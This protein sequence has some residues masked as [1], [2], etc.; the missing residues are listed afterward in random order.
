VRGDL[1]VVVGL[2]L[3]LAACERPSPALICH[4]A[5]CS[6]SVESSRDATL[7][8]LD[9]S[10]ALRDDGRPLFDGIEID[11]FW[12]GAAAGCRFAHD[13]DPAA[14]PASVAAGR[15]AEHLATSRDATW[16]GEPFHLFLDLK[17]H[18]G[19]SKRSRHSAAQ[20]AL[21]A[22]CA[23]DVVAV[24]RD[25]ARAG[26]HA[27]EVVF[28]SRSPELLAAVAAESRFAELSTGQVELRLGGDIGIPR[29]LSGETWPLSDF[30]TSLGLEVMAYSADFMTQGQYQAMRALDLE[31]AQW[32]NTTTIEALDG[33]ER[34]R[35]E[36]VLSSEV[37]LVRSWLR[38]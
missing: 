37:P 6:G 25:G 20:R 17:A 30:G 18:V 19:A 9:A 27:L 21:H 24:V 13:F 2:G 33:I 12:D 5:N 28:T 4:N 32:M 22:A 36:Y 16:S 38:R 11:L 15:V 26:G 1:A 35:P 7:P 29:P 8:A 31:L 34:Y 10:L 23:L 14:P 3:A